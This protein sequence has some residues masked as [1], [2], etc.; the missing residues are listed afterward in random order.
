MFYSLNKFRLKTV[1]SRW[2][3]QCNLLI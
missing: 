2:H 3:T 1:K